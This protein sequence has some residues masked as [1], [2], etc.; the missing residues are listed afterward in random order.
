M[1]SVVLSLKG[2]KQTARELDGEIKL[3]SY[4]IIYLLEI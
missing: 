1:G 3:L 2:Y 4:L